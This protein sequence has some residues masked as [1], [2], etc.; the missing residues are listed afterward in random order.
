MEREEQLEF[1]RG[2]AV[3]N[4]SHRKTELETV[5][6]RKQAKLDDF[7]QVQ[8]QEKERRDAAAVEHQRKIEVRRERANETAAE[9]VVLKESMITR[10]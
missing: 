10:K 2:R 4:Q 7:G 8:A 5:I 3:K 6:E 1:A 9:R